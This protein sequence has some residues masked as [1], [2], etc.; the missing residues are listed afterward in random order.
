MTACPLARPELTIVILCLDEEASIGHCVGEARGFLRRN[1][2]SG[3]VLVVDN[4]SRDRSAAL[5][6]EAGARV[7]REPARGYGNAVMAGIEAARGRPSNLGCASPFRHGIRS[8]NEGN[9]ASQCQCTD[10][11]PVGMAFPLALLSSLCELSPHRILGGLH[12]LNYAA[13]RLN[14]AKVVDFKHESYDCQGSRKTA[15]ADQGGQAGRAAA[16]PPSRHST[17]NPAS[18]MSPASRYIAAKK[19]GSRCSPTWPRQE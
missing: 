11:D 19:R 14:H 3:E 2:V 4:G 15:R 7:V 1:A 17:A 18:S 5:A 10:A 9:G 16:C 6:E 8:D 12:R 13:S